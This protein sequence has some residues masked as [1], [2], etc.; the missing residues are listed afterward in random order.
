MTP[1]TS[2][3]ADIADRSRAIVDAAR[4]VAETEGWPAV[5]VRRLAE[6]IGFSQP[7]LYRCFPA[8]RDEIV[9]QVMI[10][11][12]LE[13]GAVLAEPAGEA[14]PLA[15]VVQAYLAFAHEH[16]ALYDAMFEARTRIVFAAEETPAPLR[17][18]F[19]P[20]LRAASASGAE[21]V[22][23][24]VRAELLWSLLHGVARLA[25]SGRLDPALEAARRDAIIALF[26]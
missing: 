19:A 12:F 17:D 1:S 23:A 24:V 16:P 11:G 6:E 22:D 25:A 14:Y 9:E 2:P 21:G 4:R 15:H 26:R 3:R 10:D 8:G 13:M 18:A 5:T 7:I 20:F